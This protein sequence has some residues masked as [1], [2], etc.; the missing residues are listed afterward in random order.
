MD[1]KAFLLLIII[2]A[3]LCISG[4]TSKVERNINSLETIVTDVEENGDNYSV[5]DWDQINQKYEKTIDRIAASSDK[6]TP[7]QNREIGRLYARYH[8]AVMKS[9]LN[10]LSDYIDA[11][12][13]QLKGYSEEMFGGDWDSFLE[14]NGGI[15][16]LF[17][18][19]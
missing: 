11:A 1:K 14:D 4:C 5:K 10:S 16:N 13:E 15:E 19:L 6:L 2:F 7:E 3:S 17:D 18:D 8:K 9:A 12:D